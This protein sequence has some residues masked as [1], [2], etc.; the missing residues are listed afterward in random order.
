MSDE[1]QT[2]NDADV[3]AVEAWSKKCQDL[4]IEL[5][6]SIIGQDEVI[7]QVLIAILARGHALLEGV[8]GLAKTLMISS[9]SLIHI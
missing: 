5:Q 7:E 9:L 6:K 4:R 1:N 2:T 8:P 3:V